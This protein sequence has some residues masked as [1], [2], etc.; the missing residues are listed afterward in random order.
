MARA[1]KWAV[2]AI[3]GSL[4]MFALGPWL[5]AQATAPADKSVPFKSTMANPYRLVENW[6]KLGSIPPGPAIGKMS[7]NSPISTSSPTSSRTS[8]I[9]ASTGISPASI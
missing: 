5:F 4:A 7:S 1:G 2:S 3:T 8:R 6:P 9:K